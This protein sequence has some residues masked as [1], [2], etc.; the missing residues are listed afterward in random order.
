VSRRPLPRGLPGFCAFIFFAC[1]LLQGWAYVSAQQVPEELLD[2]AARRSGL[3]REELLR[4]YRQGQVPGLPGAADSSLAAEPGRTD[5]AGIDDRRPVMP[6]G[7]LLSLETARLAGLAPASVPP[8]STTAVV[9]S[10]QFFGRDFFRLEPGVFAPSSFGPVP[11][12]YLIGVGDQIVVDVWGEVEFRLERVVDR[13]GSIILPKGGKISCLNRTLAQLAQAVR[14]RLARS[15]SGISREPGKGTTFVDVTL[16]RLRAIRVFV[17]GDAVQPGAY[18]LSSVATVFTALYAAGGPSQAGSMRD[19]HLMRGDE[20]LARLDLYAY[21]LE[22]RRTGDAIL[23][24]GDTVFVPRRG[25]SVRLTGQVRRP[26][27]FELRQDEGLA[28]LLRFGGGFTARAA[29]EI[30]HVERILPAAERAPDAPDRIVLDIALDPLSGLPRDPAAAELRDGDAVQVGTIADRLENWVEIGGNVKRP[31]RFEYREGMDVTVLIAL[32]AGLWPDTLEERALIDRIAPDGTY[33]AVNFDLGAALAGR[34]PPVLL[35]PRDRV[36]IFSK[37]DVQDHYEVSISGEVRAPGSFPYREGLT[38]RDV[39]LKA[40]GLKESADLLRAEVSRLRRDAVTSHETGAPPER[41]VDVIALPLGEDY[42]A[43]AA[44]FLLEAHDQV[45]IRRLPWWELPRTVT[46]RG[47]VYYPGVYSLERPDERLSEIITRAGGLKPTAFAPG[48]RIYRSQEDA[49]NIAIELNR[50]ISGPQSQY[51]VI[52]RAG[53]E[54]LVPETQHTVKVA[55]AVGSPTSL[56]FKKG[57]SLGEYVDRAGG[58]AEGADKWKTRVVYPNGLSRPIKRIWRD[59]SV[60]PGS[61]IVV[62]VQT[63]KEENTL[64]TV[65]EIAAIMASLATVYLVID[66]TTN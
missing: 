17:V 8:E 44:S 32:A 55:G 62:P 66:R 53:D 5:L 31:G 18:E 39:I 33:E 47:E 21:L 19:V 60:M 58:Y 2:E 37:W 64:E 52:L 36:R 3:S 13:D 22:G 24:E 57:M 63:P 16:G 1:L 6:N 56:L 27:V 34:V 38:L 15:Y 45:A 12:D 28:D 42:L 10:L 49:G 26:A 65:R 11:E 7:P 54:V 48:A 9:D 41:M 4:R 23:R 46:V 30:V 43:V 50:A 59:P 51:D 14:E 40:G 35:Q 61:T 25:A 29:T 20:T